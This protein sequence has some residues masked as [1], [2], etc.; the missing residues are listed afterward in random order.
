MSSSISVGSNG[1]LTQSHSCATLVRWFLRHKPHYTW[2]E[3]HIHQQAMVKVQKS[4][5]L[6]HLLFKH[7][8]LLSNWTTFFMCQLFLLTCYQYTSLQKITTVVLSLIHLDILYRINCWGRIFSK[9]WV[10]MGCIPS[11]A[12]LRLAIEVQV[13]L[14]L[15]VLRSLIMSSIK[16]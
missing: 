13:Q 11:L 8:H 7:L 12:L 14:L 5:I 1:S 10:R 4:Y 9:G 6:V 3:Q 16:D 15:L 2:S